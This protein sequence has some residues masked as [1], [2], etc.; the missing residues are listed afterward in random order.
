MPEKDLALVAGGSLGTS[1]PPSRLAFK[2]LIVE[3]FIG[4]IQVQQG[5]SHPFGVHHSGVTQDVE[6][7]VIRK[8]CKCGEEKKRAA[9]KT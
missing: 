9:T 6:R 1:V 8:T 3:I 5:F 2:T 7:H 4:I